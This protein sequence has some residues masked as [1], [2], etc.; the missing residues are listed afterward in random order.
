MN[1]KIA[2][3]AAVAGTLLVSTAALSQEAVRIYGRLNL[4][5]DRYSAT[6]A[7]AGSAADYKDRTRLYDA[8]SRIGFEGSEDLGNGLKA[9]FLMESGINIDTGGTTGQSGAPNPYTGFWNSRIGHVG[10][11]GN[12]GRFTMGKSNVWWGNGFMEQAAANYLASGTPSFYGLLGRGMNV[13]VQRVSNAFQY[14]AQMGGYALQV[15]YSPN[16]ETAA[17]GA[18]ADGRL[19]AVT[20]QG[21]WG[22]FGAGYDWVKN[23]GN[24]PSTGDAASSTGHKARAGWQYAPTSVLSLIWVKSVQEN[25][26]GAVIAAPAVPLAT[27]VASGVAPENAQSRVQQTT[28]GVNWEHTMGNTQTFL[29]WSKVND[30]TGCATA[31]SCDDTGATS[32][33]AGA[34]LNLSKRTGVYASYATIKNEANYNMDY[35]GAWMTSANT[36]GGQAPGLPLTSKGADPKMFGVGVMHNF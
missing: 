3:L 4:G 13:N 25:G 24:R 19:F 18:N 14:S 30:M 16:G 28:W 34:R 26:G 6:G 35:L 7:T 22:P 1:K 10:L 15:T 29:Q 17:A 20:A 12:W 2:S 27:L 23:R 11:Q 32:W 31:G 21:Q 9:I 36:L 33:M 8:G 5:L